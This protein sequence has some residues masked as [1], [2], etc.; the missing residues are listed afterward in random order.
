VTLF[1]RRSLAALSLAAS[2]AAP[3]AV[4]AEVALIGIG[5]IPGTARDQSGLSGLLEDGVTPGDLI[6]GFGSAVT[7]S[8]S[9]KRYY[10]TPDR[11]P[12]DGTTSY[13]DRLYTLEIEVT[14]LAPNA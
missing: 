1:H 2:L 5:V 6:G 14:R 9:G 12:A 4:R 13:K 10:A 3:G 8:G 7:Y 11:G